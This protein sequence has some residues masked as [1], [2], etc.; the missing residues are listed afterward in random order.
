MHLLGYKNYDRHL[1]SQTDQDKEVYSLLFL[2]S[3][4]IYNEHSYYPAT[5]GTKL[6]CDVE[7]LN[8]VCG[9]IQVFRDTVHH[10]QAPEIHGTGDTPGKA[11]I[12]LP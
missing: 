4:A 11:Q 12:L 6:L 7:C 2:K 10:V 3:G 8:M 5:R 9:R 1:G